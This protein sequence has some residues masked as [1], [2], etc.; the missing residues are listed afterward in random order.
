MFYYLFLV[1]QWEDS[2]DYIGPSISFFFADLLKAFHIFYILILLLYNY[3]S[4]FNMGR[5]F[6]FMERQGP[7]DRR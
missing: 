3:I 2:S 4:R 1:G 6:E 7:S 5:H